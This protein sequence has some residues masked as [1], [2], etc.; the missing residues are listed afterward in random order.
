MLA[1]ARAAAGLSLDTAAA[2]AGMSGN[3]LGKVEA[4]Q[5]FLT[6]RQARLLAKKFGYSF[7]Y[8]YADPPTEPE[9]GPARHVP[10]LPR[11]PQR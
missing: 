8:L 2:A 3:A 10:A 9:Q 11:H 6:P 1:Y 5:K 4:E 7:A